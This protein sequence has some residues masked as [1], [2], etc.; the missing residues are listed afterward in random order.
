MSNWD[1]KKQDE[2]QLDID[3]A[4]KTFIFILKKLTVK[5]FIIILLILMMFLIYVVYINDIDA[6]NIHYR[7]IMENMTR[8]TT[9]LW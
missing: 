4:I 6:C 5:D 1:L 7:N 8:L 3:E 2:E 9:S